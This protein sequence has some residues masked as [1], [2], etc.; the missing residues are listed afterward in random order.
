[1]EGPVNNNGEMHGMIRAT[2]YAQDGSVLETTT[3][4]YMNGV[5]MTPDLL[6]IRDCAIRN[7]LTFCTKNM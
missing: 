6:H 4:E 7:G 2:R 3:F 1:M 5:K